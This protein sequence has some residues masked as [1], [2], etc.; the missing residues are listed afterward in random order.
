MD[1]SLQLRIGSVFILFGASLIGVV[2]PLYYS[3]GGK[4]EFTA[5]SHK[6]ITESDGFRIVRTFAA[7]IMLGVAFIHLL[8]DGVDKLLSVSLDYPPLGYTLA[9]VGA[10]LV[11]GFEQIAMTMINSNVRNGEEGLKNSK[12]IESYSADSPQALSGIESPT[13]PKACDHGRAINMISNASSFTVIVKAYMME[14]SI[15]I[16]SIIIGVAV[17]G[18]AGEENIQ[19]L[20]ALIIAI[21]FHQ[22]FEGLGL[23]TVIAAARLHFGTAKMAIFALVFALTV[24]IGV[25]IGIFITTDQ[26]I[27]EGPSVTQ[28][29]TEGCLNSLAAGIMIYI[30]LVEMIADDFQAAAIAHNVSLKIKM[31]SSLVIGNLCMAILALWA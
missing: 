11:L 3:S 4:T 17:G 24:P 16:H 15:A 25:I 28:Q 22:F 20:Q 8:D 23:G 7:G 10:L 1:Y 13:S 18:L 2:A 6:D 5:E 19:S 9:T 31:F 14:I 26:S 29:Y 27:E 12:D 21:A 30:A